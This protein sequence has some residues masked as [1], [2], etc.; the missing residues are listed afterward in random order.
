MALTSRLS[1]SRSNGVP[2]IRLIL[3]ALPR[4]EL[5]RVASA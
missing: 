3:G 1:F 5:R 4:R 2:K